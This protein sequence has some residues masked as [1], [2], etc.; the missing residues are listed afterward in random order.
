MRQELRFEEKFGVDDSLFL[1]VS[2]CNTSLSNVIKCVF[3]TLDDFCFFKT[4]SQS[5]SHVR[6]IW[7][8]EADSS[9]DHLVS[10]AVQSS[11]QDDEWNAFSDHWDCTVDTLVVSGSDCSGLLDTASCTCFHLHR[12]QLWRTI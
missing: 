1:D 7:A 12:E 9:Q 4:G 3:L 10:D 11:E 6:V 2:L 5:F 8:I